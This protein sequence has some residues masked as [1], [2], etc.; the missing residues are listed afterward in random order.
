M[1]CDTA[2]K[3]LKHALVYSHILAMPDL[4]ASFVLLTDASD[5]V[6]G[7][8]LVQ[9]DWPVTFTSKALSSPQ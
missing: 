4:D 3:Q 1:D 7:A 5:L 8:V 6:V 9:H 2:F